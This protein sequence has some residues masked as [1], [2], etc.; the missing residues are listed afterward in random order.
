M[1]QEHITHHIKLPTTSNITGTHRQK[2]ISCLYRVTTYQQYVWSLGLLCSWPQG[3]ELV[4][5]LPQRYDNARSL[6]QYGSLATK[7]LNECVICVIMSH[8]LTVFIVT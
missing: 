5:R 4:T 1:S 8:S 3:L 2:S 6:R 7:L